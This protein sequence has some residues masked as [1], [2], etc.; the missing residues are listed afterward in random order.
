[1][2]LTLAALIT[3]SFGAESIANAQYASI[4]SWSSYYYAP[5]YRMVYYA[6]DLNG[7]DLTPGALAGR[8]ILGIS[9]DDVTL[10]SSKENKKKDKKDKKDK[11]TAEVDNVDLNGSQFSG[12]LGKK[13]LKGEDFVGA[14]FTAN[15]DDGS[16]LE[17]RIE[18]IEKHPDST[19]NNLLLHTVSYA[20]ENGDGYLCGLDDDGKPVAAVALRG[21]WDLTQGTATGGSWIADND[22]FTFGCVDAALGK[23]V[24]MGYMPWQKA[25]FCS[26]DKATDCEETTLAS[27]HQAC[28]RMLRADYCGDG[29]SYTV[30]N[31]ELNVYDS[32]G[33]QVDTD[34]WSLEAEWDAN[35]A[36][37]AT[38]QR[39]ETS[40][41]TCW[42]KL[43][44]STCGSPEYLN[45]GFTLLVSE[46]EP[47]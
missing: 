47:F 22:S 3:L 9:L 4:S 38:A 25:Y 17:L 19:L 24:A 32:M 37:C 39:I 26:M 33:L 31:V 23:C 40:Q 14:R 43:Y 1:M 41:P 44:D 27:H 34:E 18:A 7:V 13:K 30:D 42:A 21:R 6:R 12:T 10:P 16:T 11:K 2:I 36:I 46:F 35:G 15:L 5:V 28:T 29:T 8:Q 20:T 45:E